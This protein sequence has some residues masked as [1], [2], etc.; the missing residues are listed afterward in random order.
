MVGKRVGLLAGLLVMAL[1]SGV[2][3]MEASPS[4]ATGVQRV[5]VLEAG[6]ALTVP[7][8]L[9]VETPMQE[10][11]GGVV[12]VLTAL[13]PGSGGC[14][15]ALAPP[16]DASVALRDYADVVMSVAKL[17]PTYEFAEEMADVSLPVGPALRAYMVQHFPE[18]DLHQARYILAAPDGFA[19]LS[20]IGYDRPEDDWFSV[21]ESFEFLPATTGPV[22]IGGRIELP[23]PG[24]AL[25][26]PD[27]WI[28]AD[29]THPDLI[30]QLESMPTTGSWLGAALEG[31]LGASFD[32]RMEIGHEMVLWASP[33][34]EGPRNRQHC[35]AWVQ[36]STM[37][38]IRELV[39]LNSEHF[40]DDP[41]QTWARFDL[42]AGQAA[43]HDLQWSPTSFGSEYIFLDDQRLVTVGCV[44]GIPVEDV[45][46]AAR[47][48]AW[49]SIAET[50]EFLPAEE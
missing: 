9:V 15:I 8:D 14:W 26:V 29:L 47:R 24:F 37:T 36:A 33:A 18:G 3:A 19:V 20:C 38:S 17:N 10:L 12:Q 4:P 34:E 11:G 32:D 35:E 45:D 46:E 5:E 39:E 6:V 2:A 31:S 23:D 28:A 44:Q 40:R 42:P 22:V 48:D 30:Q 1:G 7:D 13:K 27:G 21:A 16:A 41:T 50:I 43:R 25:E 49:L